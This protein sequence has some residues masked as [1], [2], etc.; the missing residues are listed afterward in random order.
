MSVGTRAYL[1]GECVSGK[2]MIFNLFCHFYIIGFKFIIYSPLTPNLS[3]VSIINVF[4]VSIM[5]D[6]LF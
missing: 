4:K 1:F 3:L 6:Y 2:D 5:V